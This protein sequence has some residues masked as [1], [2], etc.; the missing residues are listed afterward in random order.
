M[1]L[2]KKNRM[3]HFRKNKQNQKKRVKELQKRAQFLS[4]LD[5]RDKEAAAKTK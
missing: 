2:V 5:K 3:D 4:E 1:S